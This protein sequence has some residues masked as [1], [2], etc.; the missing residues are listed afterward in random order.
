MQQISEFRIFCQ[1]K[2]FEHKDEIYNWTNELVCYDDTYYF[3]KHKYVLKRMF[4][5]RNNAK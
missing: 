3:N 1:D 4:K 2:W 5:G